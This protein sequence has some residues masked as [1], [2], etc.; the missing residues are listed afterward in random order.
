ML[1]LYFEDAAAGAT[2]VLRETNRMSVNKVRISDP[3]EL[4][5]YV[6]I[7]EIKNCFPVSQ[8]ATPI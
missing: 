7:S 4:V 3:A 2:L 5:L 1:Q 6:F 8:A